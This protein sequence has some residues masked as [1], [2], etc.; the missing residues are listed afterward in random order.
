MILWPHQKLKN[1]IRSPIDE[2]P[3]CGRAFNCLDEGHNHGDE[4]LSHP[5]K[6]VVYNPQ[7]NNIENRSSSSTKENSVEITDSNMNEENAI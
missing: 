7:E 4:S 1:S 5:V 3:C 2:C 6:L